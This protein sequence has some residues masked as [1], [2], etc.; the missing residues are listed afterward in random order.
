MNIK[1]F[2]DFLPSNFRHEK[3]FIQKNQFDYER[4]SKLNDFE[5]NIIQ[6]DFPLCTLNNL[7]KLR[8]ISIFIRDISISPSEAYLLLHCG[9][10]S[11]DSLSRLTPYELEQKIKRL[12]RNLRVKIETKITLSILKKWIHKAN[13]KIECN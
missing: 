1:Y 5:I 9:V 3:S 8:A 13:E 7:K 4:L 6:K 10:H 11:I 12:E 2:L